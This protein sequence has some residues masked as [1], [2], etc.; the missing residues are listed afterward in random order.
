MNP[1]LEEIGHSPYAQLLTLCIAASPEKDIG[2]RIMHDVNRPSARPHPLFAHDKWHCTIAHP[3][4]HKINFRSSVELY[5]TRKRQGATE[6]QHWQIWS[7]KKVPAAIS[8]VHASVAHCTSRSNA[9]RCVGSGWG[10]GKSI[11]RGIGDSSAIFCHVPN[12]YVAAPHRGGVLG[13]GRT[14]IVHVDVS[15]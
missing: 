6:I 2:R 8:R 15:A 1:V 13:D 9:L 4:I 11:A 14:A 5:P 10:R 12:A 7:L 3:I